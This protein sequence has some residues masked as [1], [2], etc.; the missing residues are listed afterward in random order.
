MIRRKSFKGLTN[1]GSMKGV[2]ITSEHPLAQQ[3]KS[4]IDS[5]CNE[6]AHKGHSIISNCI[7]NKKTL[8]DDDELFV[9]EQPDPKKWFKKVNMLTINAQGISTTDKEGKLMFYD[10]DG[11]NKDIKDFEMMEWQMELKQKKKN[12]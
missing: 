7:C 4:Y 2:V 1:E 8:N 12:K 3:L 11:D 10:A 9:T 5:L 6:L